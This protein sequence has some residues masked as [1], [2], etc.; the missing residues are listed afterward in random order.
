MVLT[1][2]GAGGSGPGTPTRPGV[3]CPA[4]RPGLA[5]VVPIRPGSSV[6]NEGP[7]NEGFGAMISR[8]TQVIASLRTQA[9][10]GDSPPRPPSSPVRL[11]VPA[12]PD[13]AA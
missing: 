3:A 11:M 8:F 6:S 4:C 2:D 10:S 1:Y 7:G 9:A 5:Q 13:D 12:A